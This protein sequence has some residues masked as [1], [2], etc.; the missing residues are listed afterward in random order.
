MHEI[1]CEYKEIKCV[2]FEVS[3]QGYST[4]I[5]LAKLDRTFA[6]S[7]CKRLKFHS[8]PNLSKDAYSKIFC[9]TTFG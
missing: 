9:N 3:V 5:S 4:C 8:N 6:R 7:C 1:K 2:R